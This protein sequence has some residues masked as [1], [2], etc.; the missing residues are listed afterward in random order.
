MTVDP[1]LEDLG[2]LASRWDD[3]VPPSRY[4][5]NHCVLAARVLSE[6]FPGIEVIGVNIL[7]ANQIAES[8]GL[9]RNAPGY[10][11]VG[12]HEQMGRVSDSYNGHVVALWGDTIVDMSARQF[13]RPAKGIRVRGPIV[14]RISDAV[15]SIAAGYPTARFDLR[16]L[17]V[18]VGFVHYSMAARPQR[19]T[20]NP[21]WLSN[22]RGPTDT[23]RE[24]LKHH[25]GQ[26]EGTS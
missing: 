6:L 3:V 4:H 20:A 18:G 24:V 11:T 16:D 26:P 14:A 21:D 7:V 9:D 19:W 25:H 10:W 12:Y 8:S 17:G 22:W 23:A 1:T 2:V 13:D 15:G 5:T